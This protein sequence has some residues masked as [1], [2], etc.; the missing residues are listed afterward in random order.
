VK[1]AE[2]RAL[3]ERLARARAW[4]RLTDDDRE[5]LRTEA[6]RDVDEVVVSH[7]DWGEIAWMLLDA[8]E[9]PADA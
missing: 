4:T 1:V 3:V 2:Q 6:S 8:A 9:D 5:A 7:H